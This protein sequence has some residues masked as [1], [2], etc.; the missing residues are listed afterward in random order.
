MADN[1]K[2]LMNSIKP[3]DN[4]LPDGYMTPKGA[5]G[6]D[7]VRDVI[8]R[9]I[10]TGNIGSNEGTITTVASTTATIATANVTTL[11]LSGAATTT[12]DNS[13][14]DVAYIP[15]ILYDNDSSVVANTVPI[16]T[17]RIQ[18]TP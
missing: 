5:I 7:N 10:H 3:N 2:K 1:A 13:S 9:N 8:D 6:Y 15:M 17:L 16:G 11:A 18:Y 12:Y 14:A 4:S